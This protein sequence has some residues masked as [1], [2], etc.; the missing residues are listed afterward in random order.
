MTDFAAV[1]AT[2]RDEL[3]AQLRSMN[4]ADAA[5]VVPACPEWTVKDVAAHVAGLVADLLAGHKPPLGTPEMTSRQV[6]ERAGMT[7]AE[8]CDEW[9]ANADGIAAIMAETPLLAMG[10]TADLAVHHGDI[11]E[12][13]GAVSEPPPRAVAVACERYMPLLQERVAERLDIALTVTLDEQVW[14][15]AAG[16]TP[17]SLSA[18]RVDALRS[19]TGR[20]TRAEVESMLTWDGD[21]ADILDGALLQYGPYRVG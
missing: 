15:P 2:S 5:V 10:L 6:D 14:S 11:A 18:T 7:L 3:V 12:A 8:V 19:V 13:V 16:A 4:D 17:R 21:A 1:Y 20:R 9:L